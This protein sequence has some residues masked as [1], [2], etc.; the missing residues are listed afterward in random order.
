MSKDVIHQ[1]G[2]KLFWV[3]IIDLFLEIFEF[4]FLYFEVNR[5]RKYLSN[6]NFLDVHLPQFHKNSVVTSRE[7]RKLI[8]FEREQI[9][10]AISL[11]FMGNFLDKTNR[12]PSF[13]HIKESDV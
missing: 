2:Q 3:F 7:N 1:N 13:W 5:I 12:L 11:D 10:H 9:L 6:F 4:D 8:T